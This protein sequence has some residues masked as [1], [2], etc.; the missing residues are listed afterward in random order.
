MRAAVIA[1]ASELDE[2][3]STRA[4]RS[5]SGSSTVGGS[6]SS[7]TEPLVFRGGRIHEGNAQSPGIEREVELRLTGGAPGASRH[8]RAKTNS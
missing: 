8:E 3:L 1:L 6:Q 4:L 7:P 2:W 5:S